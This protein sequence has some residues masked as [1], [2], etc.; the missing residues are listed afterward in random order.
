[1]QWPLCIAL[2]TKW[3]VT[4][5]SCSRRLCV[6]PTSQQ[7]HQCAQSPSDPRVKLSGQVPQQRNALP[8]LCMHCQPRS[9]A[10]HRHRSIKHSHFNTAAKTSKTQNSFCQQHNN[11]TKKKPKASK[12]CKLQ[13]LKKREEIK[14]NSSIGESSA[15]GF[16]PFWQYYN[17]S[18]FL[19][20]CTLCL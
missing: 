4:F 16:C 8:H 11:E 18:L 10:T 3:S 5:P 2:L 6:L 12:V 7:T 14:Y 15:P 19:Q 9:R 13:L 20:P 17:D 1:M